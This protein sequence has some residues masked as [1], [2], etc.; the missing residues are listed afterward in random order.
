MKKLDECSLRTLTLIQIAIATLVS[1]IFQFIIPL[2]WQPLDV[3]TLGPDVRHG[4]P[5]ANVVLFALSQWYF[6]ISIAWLFY[7]NNKHLNNFLVYA[8]VPTST[9]IFTEFFQ[10]YLYYDY[11]HLLPFFVSFYII[12]KKRKNLFPKYVIYY[13]LIT[14]PWAFIDY[15]FKLAYYD[16]SFPEFL[17][18]GIMFLIFTIILSLI[19]KPS[20]IIKIFNKEAKVEL[21]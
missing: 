19:I 13:L 3:Y 7:R 18:N 8:L 4:D 1:L 16:S 15:F 20:K 5:G 21:D 10:I 14:A 17:F 6:S 11:I 12:I 2:N 9:I